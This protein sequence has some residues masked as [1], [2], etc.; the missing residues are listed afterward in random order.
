VSAG[1]PELELELLDV[2]PPVPELEV[3][4]ELELEV[5]PPVLE[6]ELVLPLLVECDDEEVWPPV[7]VPPLVELLQPVLAARRAPVVRPRNA[8]ARDRF[9]S[10]SLLE[11]GPSMRRI[12]LGLACRSTTGNFAAERGRVR[13]H[14]RAFME[15]A[16]GRAPSSV[17][18]CGA[19]LPFCSGNLA[20]GP[21]PCGRGC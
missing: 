5:E 7:L 21:L 12:L 9:I 14:G 4:P 8:R 13:P 11:S 20:V 15:L 10:R 16:F 19:P 6:P 1:A 2:D 17:R 18:A 3:E